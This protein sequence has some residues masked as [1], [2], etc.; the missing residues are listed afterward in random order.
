MLPDCLW[1]LATIE[2]T[3]LSFHNIFYKWSDIDFFVIATQ[4]PG[5]LEKE[6]KSF[7]QLY[8]LDL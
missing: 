2:A 7:G 6:T 3:W 4:Q 1:I 5:T 8:F